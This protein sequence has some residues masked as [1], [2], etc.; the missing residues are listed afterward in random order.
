MAKEGAKVTLLDYSEKAIEY[1]KVVSRRLGT[2]DKLELRCENMFNFNESNKYDLSW[3]CGV[4]EHYDDDKIIEMIKK[5]ASFVKKDKL[6]IV[7]IPNLLS[8][9]SIYWMLKVGKNSE[10]YLSHSRLVFLMRKSGLKNIQIKNFNYWLPSF[11]PYKWAIKSSNFKVLNNTKLL[12]W[13]FSGIGT[14]F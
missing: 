12:S 3:N 9:Q 11:F 10:R 2:L 8:P 5:M 14:K 1:A 4:I 13:L 6:V 7:T